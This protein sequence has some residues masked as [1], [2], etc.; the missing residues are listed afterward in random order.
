[1]SFF[2]LTADNDLALVVTN[3]TTGKKG[4]SLSKDVAYA[5]ATKS[6][7]RL[8]FWEGEWFLDLRQ[9]TPWLRYILVKSPNLNLVRIIVSKI[10]LSIPSIAS[11]VSVDVSL[12]AQREA[13][14]TFEAV[15][16]D[17]RTIK[18]GVGQPFIVEGVDIS[19][20]LL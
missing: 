17:G 9:G 6:K 19:E 18:G 1:M 7:S 11:V 5:A 12:N 3:P 16:S 2:E 14:I 15:A 4:L 10:L 13:S 8:L 20:G